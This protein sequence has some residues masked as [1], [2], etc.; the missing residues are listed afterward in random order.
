MLRSAHR[1]VA[2]LATAH[3]REPQHHVRQETQR[4][5]LEISTR[6]YQRHGESFDMTRS[7]AWAGWDRFWRKIA[8]SESAQEGPLRCLD[9]GCGNGRFALFLGSKVDSLEYLGVD[10]DAGLLD[11]ARTVPPGRHR[12]R[13]VRR[14][15]IRDDLSA[16]VPEQSQDLVTLFGVLHHVPGEASRRRLLR[17]LGS[18]L[19]GGGR[20]AASIWRLD[21]DEKRFARKRISWSEWHETRSEAEHVDESDLDVG[22]VLLSWK[23]DRT[24]PRYC[25]FP[26]DAEIDR[27][28][29]LGP[30]LAIEHRF[31]ADGPTGRDNLYLVWRR[32]NLP[33]P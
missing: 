32:A 5:L 21:R 22:D 30:D 8:R 4:R 25:H 29:A 33:A 23:G 15:L 10:L 9:A 16:L 6:F 28:A 2:A 31:E 7:R 24:T 27:L 17:E 20:L 14:D 13:F 26:D 11:S 1:V 18:R 3:R 12:L 19:T